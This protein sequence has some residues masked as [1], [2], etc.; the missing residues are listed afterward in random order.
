[1]AIDWI[2][3][4]QEQAEVVARVAEDVARTL[5][6][7]DL[8]DAQALRL[9]LMVEQGAS[10]FDSILDEMDEHDVEDDLF[11]AAADIADTWTNLS[12]ST[13]NKLRALEGLAPIKFPPDAPSD[14]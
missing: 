6:L 9:H 10:T 11:E 12:V 3:T 14:D 8:S 4:V 5:E 7:P 1:M 13:A 2:S